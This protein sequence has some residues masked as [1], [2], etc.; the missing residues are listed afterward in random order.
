[1]GLG[2]RGVLLA[3]QVSLPTAD[4][5]AWVLGALGAAVALTITIAQ[6]K[7]HGGL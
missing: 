3:H 1:M 4:R 7:V 5:L 6:M 2:L